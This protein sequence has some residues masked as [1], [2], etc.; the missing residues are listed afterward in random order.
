MRLRPIG[1][2]ASQLQTPATFLQ[3]SRRSAANFSGRYCSKQSF[4]LVFRHSWNTYCWPI[5]T[6]LKPWPQN[7][8]RRAAQ[9]ICGPVVRRANKFSTLHESR[10]VLKTGQYEKTF[11][12]HMTASR[13]SVALNYFRTGWRILFTTFLETKTQPWKLMWA[14]LACC[15]GSSGTPCI[16]CYFVYIIKENDDSFLGREHEFLKKLSLLDLFLGLRGQFD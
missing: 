15:I 3:Q 1:K 5:P 10:I 7:K 4:L 8:S 6:V 9:K 13:S 2:S 11:L 12:P 14:F 16:R